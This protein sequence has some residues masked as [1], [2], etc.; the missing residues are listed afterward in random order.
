MPSYGVNVTDDE[1]AEWIEDQRIRTRDGAREVVPRSQ[2]IREAIA[3]DQAITEV[4]E[5]PPEGL[6]VGA[7]LPPRDRDRRG[8][9]RQLV[10]DA[11]RYR[12]EQSDR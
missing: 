6:A 1:M 4:L 3:L 5:D 2:V 11:L 8:F 9:A 12:A 10:L 7:H